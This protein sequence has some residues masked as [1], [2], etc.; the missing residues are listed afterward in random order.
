MYINFIL[1]SGVFMTY[2]DKQF[3]GTKLK[4][5]RKKAGYTQEKLS[6]KLGIA[7]KHYGKLERGAFVPSLQTFFKIVETLNIPLADFGINVQNSDN[8][9]RDKILKEIYSLSN[10][11]IELY[12]KLIQDIKQYS[13]RNKL[14]GRIY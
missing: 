3:I 8:K 11:E 6:E 12:L 2:C 7:E 9:A 10:D 1:N 5:Y 4:Q 13:S 14:G